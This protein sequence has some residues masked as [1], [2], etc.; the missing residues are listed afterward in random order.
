MPT[1]FHLDLHADIALPVPRFSGD[2][3]CVQPQATP[4]VRSHTQILA[5]YS[6]YRA[7]DSVN[8]GGHSDFAAM[9]A[10]M[11]LFADD[12]DAP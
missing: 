11:P 8:A 12:F 2:G 4:G 9:R 10:V 3:S 6:L 5:G 7:G 1:R